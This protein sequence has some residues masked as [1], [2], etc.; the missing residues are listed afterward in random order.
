MRRDRCAKSKNAR[1]GRTA[2]PS[3]HGHLWYTSGSAPCPVRLRSGLGQ[4]QVERLVGDE[5]AEELVRVRTRVKVTARV[6]V[7]VRVS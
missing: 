6:R 1:P 3:G 4:A 5:A 2:L 7:R